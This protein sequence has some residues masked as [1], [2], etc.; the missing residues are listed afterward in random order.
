ME[1][2]DYLVMYDDWK[3]RDT[4]NRKDDECDED[5]DS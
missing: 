5:D 2:I 1:Q 4:D 3:Y